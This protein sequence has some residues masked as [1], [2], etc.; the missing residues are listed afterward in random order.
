[1]LS[2]DG[3]KRTDP[4]TLER[5]TKGRFDIGAM[6]AEA[7]RLKLESR[8]RIE[9]EREFAKPSEEWVRAIAKRISPASLTSALHVADPEPATIE[10]GGTDDPSDG[11]GVITTDDEIGGFRIVQAIAA[12]HVDPNRVVIR[13]RR[14][15]AGSCSTTTTARRWRGCTSTARRRYV[16]TFAG[17]LETRHAVAALTDL[18]KLEDALVGRIEELQP[19]RASRPITLCVRAQSG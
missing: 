17:K 4:Q 18:Y 14:A 13:I 9:V 7:G 15:I 1:M 3:I 11:Y 10:E 6:I 8:V 19:A 16:G 5:F 12:R 2:L